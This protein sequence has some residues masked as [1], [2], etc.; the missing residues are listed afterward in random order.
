MQNQVIVFSFTKFFVKSKTSKV[1]IFNFTNFSV[2]SNANQVIVFSF[3]KFFVKS[4]A[5]KVVV[6]FNFTN[7][8]V[9]SSA[10]QARYGAK[11]KLKLFSRNNFVSQSLIETKKRI[12][13]KK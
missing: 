4:K 7:F 11:I 5:S 9:N 8:S 10:N 3:T 1:A 2:N 6:I 13:K 12:T